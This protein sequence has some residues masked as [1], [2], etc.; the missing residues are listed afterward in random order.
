MV[1]AEASPAFEL[2]DPFRES[3]FE[4]GFLNMLDTNPLGE[5]DS[6]SDDQSK[7]VKVVRI[8][9]GMKDDVDDRRVTKEHRISSQSC[10]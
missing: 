6:P 4:K 10:D 5:R 2:V 9:A 7:T 3:D 1:S 8:D